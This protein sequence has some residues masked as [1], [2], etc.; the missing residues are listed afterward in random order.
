MRKVMPCSPLA[1][2]PLNL[3][4]LPGGDKSS[5]VASNKLDRLLNGASFALRFVNLGEY[6]AIMQGE[7]ELKGETLRHD[8]WI[9]K[10]PGSD[11]KTS[12]GKL[13]S[14]RILLWQ[15]ELNLKTDN[16]LSSAVMSDALRHSR[17][18]RQAGGHS[19]RGAFLEALRQELLEERDY[20]RHI[21]CLQRAIGDVESLLKS[22]GCLLGFG[23]Q[24]DR[25]GALDARLKTC[26]ASREA[27]EE[28]LSTS[29]L[30]LKL[31]PDIT[32]RILLLREREL[33][34]EAHTILKDFLDKGAAPTRR[35]LRVV[36]E[37]R[38][39]CSWNTSSHFGNRQ[40]H[41]VLLIDVTALA[42]ESRY[43]FRVIHPKSGAAH[44]LGAVSLIP[45]R[46]F[47]AL[48]NAQQ[49]YNA[50]FAHPIF[51]HMG[52]LAYPSHAQVSASAMSA[53]GGREIA[54]L[55]GETPT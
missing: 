28:L 3:P 42:G 52:H 38:C 35:E 51:T 47:V 55:R 7:Q 5:Q 20:H 9:F 19:A 32:Q 54:R 53:L 31:L 21:E 33:F 48:L 27:L 23:G 50:P 18:S 16:I 49:L 13:E 2:S 8:G 15:N 34:S 11:C 46:P 45:V 44:V 43:G 17:E 36:Y 40:F 30:P 1:A 4:A 6:A 37:A 29:S 24:A 26:P 12:G 22:N 10:L 41:V 14:F 39:L 25:L